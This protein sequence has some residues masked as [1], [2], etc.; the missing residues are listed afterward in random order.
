VYVFCVGV[1]SP[2]SKGKCPLSL[3]KAHEKFNISVDEFDVVAQE[4]VNALADYKVGEDD[5][6]AVLSAF[7]A[8]MREVSLHEAPAG[9]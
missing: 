8:H 4:L 1:A 6:K 7:K 2:T 3:E 5:S 9:C